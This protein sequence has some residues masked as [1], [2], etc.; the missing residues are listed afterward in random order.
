MSIH[1]LYEEREVT[2]AVVEPVSR[3]F[4][5]LYTSVVSERANPAA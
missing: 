5:S 3:Q 1:Y 2:A 4:F